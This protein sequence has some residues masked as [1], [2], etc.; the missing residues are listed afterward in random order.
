MQDPA[1]EVRL[2]RREGPDGESPR[3]LSLQNHLQLPGQA[4]SQ[5]PRTGSGK[6]G[7]AAGS[8]MSRAPAAF[9]FL[10]GIINSI[11]LLF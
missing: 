1:S 6:L 10:G 11:M 3:H 4:Q 7:E 5:G 8:W 9:H 2:E